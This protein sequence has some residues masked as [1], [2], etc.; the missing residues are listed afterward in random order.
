[1]VRIEDRPDGWVHPSGA[2]YRDLHPYD[3]RKQFK[4]QFILNW[5]AMDRRS[6]FSAHEDL[7]RY[8]RVRNDHRSIR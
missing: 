6:G 5:L 8:C 7:P 3:P 1:M 2:Q 4:R